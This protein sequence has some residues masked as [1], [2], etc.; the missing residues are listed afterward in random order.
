LHANPALSLTTKLLVTTL[1]VLV[2]VGGL[3]MMV[4]PGPGVLGIVLGLA[5]LATEYAWAERWL[6]KA[7]EKAHEA[8]LKAEAMDPKVRRRRLLLSGLMF[9]AVAGGV[10]LY[11]ALYDWPGF[12]L[13]SWDWLQ[14][15]AGWVPE[16]PGM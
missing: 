13:D 16:L 1:G 9:V 8:R 3:V 4:T 12:A 11:V 7:R 6:V 5:I 2:M 15:M 10:T 14:G